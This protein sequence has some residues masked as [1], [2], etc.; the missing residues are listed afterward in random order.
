MKKS[1]VKQGYPA[2][3][4]T[5]L[6]KAFDCINH[7]LLIAK[8]DAYGFSH[9]SLTFIQSYLHGRSQRTKVNNSYSSWNSPNTGVP[10]GSILGPI[11]LNIYLNDSLYLVDE[12]NL[13]NYADD[14]TPF[15]IGDCPECV[16][17]KLEV[18]AE[19]LIKW[20][21]E[22]YLHMNADKCHLF[23]P[24]QPIE[25]SIKVENQIIKGEK[26]VKILGI[27]IDENLEVNTH[28]SNLCNK[29]SQK[30]HALTRIAPYMNDAKLKLLMRAFIESQ[31]SYCPLIWMYHNRTMNNRI[32]RIH[33]RAL[34]IV[35]GNNEA[36]FE[37]LLVKDN[38]VTIHH[39]NLQRPD[40]EVKNNLSLL[41]F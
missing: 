19:I 5:D 4:L 33:E 36:S 25:T 37:E 20:F 31:F 14:N 38:S 15:E 27:T 26:S 23:V 30:L 18:D 34:R 41:H 32:N 2:A 16:L 29:A 21:K 6:S 22:N 35:Y 7:D 9:S 40:I 1:L 10:Q 3:L 17:T 12:E 11:L 13:A 28:V 39:R 24:R 8:L